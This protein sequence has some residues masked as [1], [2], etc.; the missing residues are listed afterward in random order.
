M[1]KKIAILVG[2]GQSNEQG[3]ANVAITREATQFAP[4]GSFGGV[5]RSPFG[6]LARL[7]S[8]E[9]HAVWLRNFAVG[10]TGCLPQWTGFIRTWQ[11]S[12]FYP[13][14][15]YVLPTVPNGF[16]YQN[17][18]GNNTNSS[19]TQ[20]TW[21]TTAGATVVEG[22]ITWTCQ[23]AQP[24][25]VDNRVVVFGD[26]AYDPLGY[27]APFIAAIADAKAKGFE[28]WVCSSGHQGDM[29]LSKSAIA[30]A[31]NN[32]MRRAIGAGADRVYLGLTNRDWGNNTPST[33]WDNPGTP[34]ATAHTNFHDLR[35][36]V[37]SSLVD[38]PKVL[39]GP[40]LSDIQMFQ[41]DLEAPTTRIHMNDL[42]VMWAGRKW[43]DA[44]TV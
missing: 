6:V 19:A 32:L 22:S 14:R 4:P 31:M 40:D 23:V 9:G 27:I 41:T 38:Q 25:D 21:P 37:K 20:P 18:S 29:F 13:N 7:L 34:N 28:V 1:P 15:S 16:R 11:A 10:G 44:I 2:Y 5:S 17:T 35:N 12:A 8:E 24:Q 33:A 43:R 39:L 3:T 42:G 30:L 26:T 36:L